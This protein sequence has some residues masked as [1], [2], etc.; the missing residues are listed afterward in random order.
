[1]VIY[2]LCHADP[3]GESHDRCTGHLCECRRGHH[4]HPHIHDRDRP[5]RGEDPGVVEAAKPRAERSPHWY[6]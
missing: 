1:M 4:K 5:G 6:H 2:F 3:D